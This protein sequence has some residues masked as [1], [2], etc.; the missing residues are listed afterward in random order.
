MIIEHTVF[1]GLNIRF[2]VLKI[3]IM[4]EKYDKRMTKEAIKIEKLQ[5]NT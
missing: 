1:S 2:N 4:E 3:L 5:E